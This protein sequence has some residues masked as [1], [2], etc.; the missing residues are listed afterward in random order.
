MAP[1]LLE[2]QNYQVAFSAGQESYP[3]LREI[4]FAVRDREALGIVGESGCGKSLTALSVMGLLPKG[5][6]VSGGEARLN[7][8]SLNGLTP[9]D[10]RS[11][12]GKQ[13]AMIFQDPMTALNPLIPVGRQ[14]AEAASTHLPV[15]KRE[16]KNLALDM[17]RKVGLS[18]TEH[19]YREYPHQLSGGMRQRIMIAMAMICKPQLLIADE[20]T[21]ALDVTIQAQILDLLRE[22]KE[23]AGAAMMFISHDL[24]VIREICDRVIV[25]YAGYIVEEAP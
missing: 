11:V 15:S 3:A 14:I 7:G 22:M 2:L 9:E 10:W 21:T 19:L 4:S 17:M 1:A 8:K 24:G 23:N 16:A 20:P 5:A 13:V 18:R 25:M 12:R 6:A